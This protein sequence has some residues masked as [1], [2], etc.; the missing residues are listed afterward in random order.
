MNVKISGVLALA[1]T[2]LIGACT[3]C[4]SKPVPPQTQPTSQAASQPATK[5]SSSA[6]IKK[7]VGPI[8]RGAAFTSAE[9]TKLAMV[10]EQ[11]DA[12]EAKTV[13]VRGKV[14]RCCTKKGCWMELTAPGSTQGLRVRFKDY[15]FFVPLDSAGSS[16]LVEGQLNT[17]LLTSEMAT[18]L[19]AEGAKIFRNKDG[20]AIELSLLATAVELRR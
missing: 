12:Y 14:A 5:T 9:E 19:E 6:A 13:K 15:G 17:K 4:K 10:L 3:C 16:A 2:F 1:T 7:A 8:H 20:E 18:H 11:A